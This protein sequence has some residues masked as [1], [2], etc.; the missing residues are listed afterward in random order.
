MGGTHPRVRPWW[1]LGSGGHWY[2]AGER[3][4]E[5]LLVELP[6]G[7]WVSLSVVGTAQDRCQGPPA[8]PRAPQKQA[9]RCQGQVRGATACGESHT[10]PLC[11]RAPGGVRGAVVPAR[12][13]QLPKQQRRRGPVVPPAPGSLWLPRTCAGSR[14]CSQP[15]GRCHSLQRAAC[16]GPE[17]RHC[18]ARPPQHPEGTSPGPCAPHQ[19][20][21]NLSLSASPNFWELCQPWGCFRL[22]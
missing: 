8:G 7:L 16:A 13:A 2:R 20:H 22:R 19:N 14:G 15:W 18:S 5:E 21:P 10:Q 9:P 12:G 6:P 4:G 1:V 11:V 17:H 3:G